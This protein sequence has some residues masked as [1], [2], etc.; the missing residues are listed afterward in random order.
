M[1]NE[2]KPAQ[3]DW[4]Q[5]LSILPDHILLLDTE[6]KI[7]YVNRPSPG[8]TMEQLIGTPLYTLVEPERQQEIK[9][10][11]E[12]VIATGEQA[13]YETVYPIPDG[14]VIYYESRVVPRIENGKMVGLLLDARDITELKNV[15][16]ALEEGEVEKG[17]LQMQLIHS[18]KMEAMG[19]LTGGIAHDFNN[20][21]ASARGYTELAQM[22]AQKSGDEKLSGYLNEVL[23]SSE[24]ATR[25]VQQML[26]FARGSRIEPSLHDMHEVI[27]DAVTMLRPI[28]TSSI[29]IT[30]Q[31]DKNIPELIVDPVQINQVLMNLCINAKDAMDNSGE[32]LISLTAYSP[33][34]ECSSCHKAISGEWVNLSVQDNGPGIEPKLLHNIFEPFFSSKEIGKGSGM[35][36]SVVHG[37]VHDHDGHIQVESSPGQGTT[38]HIL[39]PVAA[40]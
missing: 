16:Q 31:L 15:Q 4:P 14:G 37:I 25:L 36:L 23:K 26:S 17:Q 6:L 40:R 29:N 9:Q 10:I 32:L 5:L 11:L 19:R 27:H 7:C 18:Q 1:D 38:F 30:T 12:G 2:T 34:G 24:R 20:I 8:I 33:S 13:S 3:V 21:L 35:G 22:L 39:L 28:L